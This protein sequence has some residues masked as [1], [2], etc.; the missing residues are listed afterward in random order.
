MGKEKE[1]DESRLEIDAR[2]DEGAKSN[3]T[4][5]KSLSEPISLQTKLPETQDSA[6]PLHV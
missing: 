3:P 2:D 1:D 4:G 6:K 5:A